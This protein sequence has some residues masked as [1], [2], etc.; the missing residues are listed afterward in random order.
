[1]STE[2][3][4]LIEVLVAFAIMALSLVALFQAIGQSSRNIAVASKVEEAVLLGR[5]KL[6]E[7]SMMGTLL[8]HRK[9]GTF[10]GG[11]RWEL[12]IASEVDQDLGS[13]L[14]LDVTWGGPDQAAHRRRLTTF[15]VVRQSQ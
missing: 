5:S 7:I 15:V 11:Y 12:V 14:H 10:P 13:W 6:T 9:R 1:M 2:G 3:F 8:D 4:T